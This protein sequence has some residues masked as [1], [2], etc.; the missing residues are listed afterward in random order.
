MNLLDPDNFKKAV[1]TDISDT[2]Q[3][4]E[5]IQD[6]KVLVLCVLDQLLRRYERNRNYPFIDT[7]LS[8][9][10]GLDFPDSDPLRGRK[11]INAWIQGRGLEAMAGHAKWISQLPDLD[12]GTRSDLLRRITRV[13]AEV[14]AQTERMRARNGGRLYF[15]MTPDGKPLKVAADGRVEPATLPQGLPAGVSEMFYCKGLAAAACAL[16]DKERL[17]AACGLF[18]EVCRDI[19]ADRFYSDHQNM[20]VRNAPAP[21]QGAFSHAGRMIGIGSAACF[22]ECAGGPQYAT[23]GLRFIDHIL[24][25]HV[26]HAPPFK[27]GQA[28]DMWEYVDRHGQPFL[29]G[30]LLR[31][32]SGHAN[33]FVGLALKLIARCE[34]SSAISAADQPRVNR[35]KQVLPLVLKKNFENGFSS[36]GIGLMKNFDLISRRP[37]NDQMPWWNLPETVRAAVE[38]ARISDGQRRDEMLTIAARC[39]NAFAQHYVRRDLWLMAP[40]TLSADGKVLDVIPA[41][42][43][44]DPGYHTGLS[45]I[46]AIK[47]AEHLVV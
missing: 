28:Y 40:Q 20:D 38:A 17:G 14:V 45:I 19:E 39:S 25:R 3:W 47:V 36:R 11:V 42:P 44:A 21:L 4:R 24:D 29:E 13:L 9:V 1:I 30:S 35:F 12:E 22:M 33:E 8:M 31:S 43:D 26:N 5:V 37:I 6:W 15:M 34:D 32:D 46:D 27:H 10:T 7:K 41:T 18:D 2:R 16:G 23:V